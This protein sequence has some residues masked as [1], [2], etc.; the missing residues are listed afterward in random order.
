ML[1]AVQTFYE[2][3]L[4]HCLVAVKNTFMLSGIITTIIRKTL[5]ITGTRTAHLYIIRKQ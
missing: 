2:G 4:L 5:K 1:Q 3:K